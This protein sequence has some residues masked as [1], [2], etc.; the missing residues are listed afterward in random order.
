MKITNP[1][2]NNE[3]LLGNWQCSDSLR[4]NLQSTS[5]KLAH[6]DKAAHRGIKVNT[7]LTITKPFLDS[8]KDLLLFKKVLGS[9]L[10]C[11]LIVFHVL[12]CFISL[13]SC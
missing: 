6:C 13:R 2:H 8:D 3:A 1:S 11:L 9:Y 10:T 4:D 5:I 7:S 12:V